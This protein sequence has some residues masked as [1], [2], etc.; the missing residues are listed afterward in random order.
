[1]VLSLSV[2]L[3]NLK[4]RGGTSHLSAFIR[5]LTLLLLCFTKFGIMKSSYGCYHNLILLLMGDP[6]KSF[7]M[8]NKHYGFNKIEHT[9]QRGF[10]VYLF[11]SAHIVL[12]LM[13]IKAKAHPG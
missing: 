8:R 6:P 9:K 4:T 12:H 1:M 11:F 2:P 7:I 10:V 13:M 3:M 5:I